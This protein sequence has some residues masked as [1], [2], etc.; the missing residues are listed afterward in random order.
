MSNELKW[1]IQAEEKFKV[2]VSKM[3]AFHRP[4]AE[5]MISTKAQ[6]F[7]KKR[8]ADVVAEEDVVR[9]FFA[10]C[11]TPFKDMMKKVLDEAGLDYKSLNL[12]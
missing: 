4:I 11:P 10:D 2:A 3:P 12:E 7:A 5:K 6:D 9:A 1:D 8:G